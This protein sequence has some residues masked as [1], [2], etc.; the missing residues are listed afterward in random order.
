MSAAGI[1]ASIAMLYR[2]RLMLPIS[3]RT[4]KSTLRPSASVACAMSAGRVPSL[5]NGRKPPAVL[6]YW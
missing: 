1:G 4:M 2:K 5:G 3:R 6:R